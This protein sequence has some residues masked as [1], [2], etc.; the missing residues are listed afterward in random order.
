MLL[1]ET[2]ATIDV[3]ESYLSAAAADFFGL[4]NKT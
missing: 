4:N 1:F 2:I 3:M